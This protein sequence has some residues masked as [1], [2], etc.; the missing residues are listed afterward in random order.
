[1]TFQKNLKI[2]AF[3]TALLTLVSCGGN[4][5]SKKSAPQK[6]QQDQLSQVD[7]KI[8]MQGR[9]FPDAGSAKVEINDELI[10][11][12]CM[13][14]QKYTIDRSVD[15]QSIT[16]M[17]HYVPELSEVKVVVSDCKTGDEPVSGMV[18]FEIQKSGE[19]SELVINL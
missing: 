16:I 12:E 18:P 13:T 4:S 9:N 2:A 15:P 11:S 6:Q 3:G 7:W 19:A 10:L 14:K 5:D 1:M 8:F 17:N